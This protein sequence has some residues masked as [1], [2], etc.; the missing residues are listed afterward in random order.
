VANTP[1]RMSNQ[2]LAPG[3]QH[4]AG[5]SNHILA[6]GNQRVVGLVPG[7]I[8]Q[9]LAPVGNAWAAWPPG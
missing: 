8:N 4:V 6:P 5:T 2:I 1:F 9:I 7:T 3:C